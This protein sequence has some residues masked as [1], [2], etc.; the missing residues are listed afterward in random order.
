MLKYLIVF[1]VFILI[2]LLTN[3]S[4]ILMTFGSIGAIVVC[5]WKSDFNFCVKLNYFKKILCF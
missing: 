4:D 5:Y 1:V 3:E 2:C